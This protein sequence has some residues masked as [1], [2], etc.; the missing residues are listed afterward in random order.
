M[1]YSES[2]A[3]MGDL[4]LLLDRRRVIEALAIVHGAD[5]G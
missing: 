5:H 3:A 4:W 2:N 1:Y